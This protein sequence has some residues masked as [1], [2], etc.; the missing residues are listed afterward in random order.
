[1]FLKFCEVRSC[2]NECCDIRLNQATVIL[3][4]DLVSFD[5]LKE[6]CIN[7]LSI[8]T[9]YDEIQACIV[10]EMMHGLFYFFR[11]TK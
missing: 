2:Q 5:N 10:Q 7:K 6:N 8:S 4:V 11:F 9:L 1:M 3:K